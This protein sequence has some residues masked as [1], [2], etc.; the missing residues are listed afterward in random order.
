MAALFTRRKIQIVL[1]ILWLLDGVLQLQKQMFTSNFANK[2]ILPAAIGQPTIVSGPLHFEIRIILAH[3]AI[4]DAAFALIQLSLGALILFKKTTRLGLI[5]SVGWALGVWY[6]GEGFNGLLSWHATLF[7][8]LPGAALL[9]AMLALANLPK[10][11]DNSPDYWLPTVWAGLWILGTVFFL[12]PGQNAPIDS[13]SMFNAMSS[14]APGWISFLDKHAALLITDTGYWF[15]A[16]VAAIQVIIGVLIFLPNNYRKAAI[17]SGIVVSVIYWIVGQQLGGYFT[18]VATDPS[19]APLFILLGLA[20]L[21][22]KQLP[23]KEL[24]HKTTHD[25]SKILV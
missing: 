20:I 3:P 9:Y 11:N 1:G 23:V 16:I 18:G 17:Y 25:M 8:G 22:C 2:V 12:L 21:G 7:M 24:W 13:S 4:I 19:T 5:A 6:M 10:S 14:G 15:V